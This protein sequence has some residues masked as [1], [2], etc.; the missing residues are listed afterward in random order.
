MM[1][2]HYDHIFEGGEDLDERAKKLFLEVPLEKFRK[3]IEALESIVQTAEWST[4]AWTNFA[5]QLMQMRPLRG[6]IEWDRIGTTPWTMFKIDMDK[7]VDA[8]TCACVHF[9]VEGEYMQEQMLP[10]I[11][12][13]LPDDWDM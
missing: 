10:N 12:E 13:L 2:K 6:V 8:K 4:A 5:M 9:A 7:L 1:D 11:W 3:H